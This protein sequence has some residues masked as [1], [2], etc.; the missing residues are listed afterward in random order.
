M[1]DINSNNL[2]DVTLE[3]GQAVLRIG[4]RY[5]PVGMNFV[6]NYLP[7]TGGTLTNPL[8]C[9]KVTSR[10]GYAFT[11]G[12]TETAYGGGCAQFFPNDHAKF[13]G[14][15]HIFVTFDNGNTLELRGAREGLT[16]NGNDIT[17]GAP[18]YTAAVS[19]SVSSSKSFTAPSNGWLNFTTSPAGLQID[20][21][22]VSAN[23]STLIPLRKGSVVT[24]TSSSAVN[25]TFFSC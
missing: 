6:G 20:G 11:F 25:G 10:D 17:F 16:W 3:P 24:T 18:K 1:S 8:V 2:Q 12:S 19:V 22:T 9:D 4:D 23:T 5:F 13:P 14:Q 15:F 21:S 7:T